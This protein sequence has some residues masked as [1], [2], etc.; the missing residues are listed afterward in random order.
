MGK[1]QIGEMQPAELVTAILIS[2]LCAIPMQDLGIPLM[3][4]V[5][6]IIILFSLELILSAVTAGSV[7]ARTII[8][9][10]TSVLIRNGVINQAE[11]KRL[12]I[13][14]RKSVV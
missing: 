12:R 2:N 6:P 7:K 10:K 3:Q 9:G 11:L 8:C 13:R 4:G 1:R 14:D 5:L